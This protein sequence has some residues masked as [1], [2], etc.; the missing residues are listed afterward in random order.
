ML[1]N[2]NIIPASKNSRSVC[3]IACD[4]E[5]DLNQFVVVGNSSI[6]NLCALFRN[7]GVADNIY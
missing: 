7:N 5:K 3:Y 1:V 2:E 6:L 4:A